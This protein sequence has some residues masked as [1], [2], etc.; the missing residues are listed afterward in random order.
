M[1]LKLL[2]KII[3]KIFGHKERKHFNIFKKN[4]GKQCVRCKRLFRYLT[5][6]AKVQFMPVQSIVKNLLLSLVVYD[7]VEKILTI[8]MIG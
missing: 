5:G 3:C 1:V 4:I 6:S 7:M 8:H 2:Y